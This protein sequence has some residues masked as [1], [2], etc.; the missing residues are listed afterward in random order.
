MDLR[1]IA[2]CGWIALLFIASGC[3]PE[4]KLGRQPVSGTITLNGEPLQRGSILFAPTDPN[5]VSSGAEVSGGTFSI[6]PHQGLT[7]GTYAVRIYA[8]DETA[9]Q[10]EP[11]LPG[12]GINTQPER[13]PPEYNIKSK[14]S[15]EVLDE[16]AVF[17]LNIE[18]R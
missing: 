12:P 6:P 13:I 15:L 18:A 2:V 9:E 4:N 14:L 8:T 17:N 10:V 7:S 3:S 16:A 1:I 5:S 11:A